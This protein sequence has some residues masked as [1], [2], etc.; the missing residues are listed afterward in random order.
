ML[1]LSLTF[2][3]AVSSQIMNI[4]ILMRHLLKHSLKAS[5]ADRLIKITY[6]PIYAHTKHFLA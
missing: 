2:K 4:L 1:R 6:I 3:L 5:L